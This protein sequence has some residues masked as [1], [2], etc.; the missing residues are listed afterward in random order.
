MENVNIYVYHYQQL[1]FSI[2]F[3]SHCQ[4]DIYLLK[5]AIKTGMYTF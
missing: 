5:N 4:V 2:I 1:I 3:T